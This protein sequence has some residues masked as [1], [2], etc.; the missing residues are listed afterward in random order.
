MSTGKFSY[1]KL[2]RGS[3]YIFN[4]NPSLTVSGDKNIIFN[5]FSSKDEFHI[6]SYYKKSK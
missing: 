4:I 5:C 3:N 6:F 1:L 2:D